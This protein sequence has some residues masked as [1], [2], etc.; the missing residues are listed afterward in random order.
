MKFIKSL[1]LPLKYLL[2][3]YMLQFC[4]SFFIGSF[5]GFI[6][7]YNSIPK[8]LSTIVSILCKI[9]ALYIYIPLLKDEY[10]NKSL[11]TILKVNKLSSKNIVI[12]SLFAITLV[13]CE[14]LLGSTFL[15]LINTFTTY[16][17]YNEVSYSIIGNFIGTVGMNF[18]LN[19]LHDYIWIIYYISIV[20][21]IICFIWIMRINS[22]NKFKCSSSTK[23]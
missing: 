21:A 19:N 5:I 3:W 17:G 4:L 20:T 2:I 8:S 11:N 16:T 13:F 15:K 7:S 23:E 6:F 12:L 22:N 14:S 1:K 18:V 9:S 10:E